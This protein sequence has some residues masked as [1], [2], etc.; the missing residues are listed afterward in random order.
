[1]TTDEML[2]MNEQ[3]MKDLRPLYLQLYAPGQN[4]SWRKNFISRFRTR[5]QRIG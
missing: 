1:M 3:F 4:T 2:K 5:F